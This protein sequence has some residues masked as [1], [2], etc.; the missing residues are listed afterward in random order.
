MDDGTE[1]LSRKPPRAGLR[2]TAFLSGF[3]EV[4]IVGQWRAASCL[5]DPAEL[6]LAAGRTCHRRLAGPPW[7]M[8][9]AVVR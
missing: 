7:C 8:R 5:M 1:A 3:R 4:V 9:H 6:L 2:A